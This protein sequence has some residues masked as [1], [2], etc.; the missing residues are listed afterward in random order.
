[1]LFAVLLA[2]LCFVIWYK[3]QQPSTIV[4]SACLLVSV[5]HGFFYFP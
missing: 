3:F 4:V 1:M 5:R 2:D